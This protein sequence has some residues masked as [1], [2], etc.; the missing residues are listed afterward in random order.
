MNKQEMYKFIDS[1]KDMQ[2]LIELIFKDEG[3]V[4]ISFCRGKIKRKTK[5]VD[6]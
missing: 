2:K 1:N 6:F 3:I 4:E 5:K